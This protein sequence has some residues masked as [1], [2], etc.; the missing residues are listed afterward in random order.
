[1]DRR[2][3]AGYSASWTTEGTSG[4]TP[5]T[6]QDW[7]EI[8]DP[9][10]MLEY[11]RGKA[12]DR[13][14]RLFACAC[15]RQVWHLLTDKRSR[16][17]VE[18]AERYADGEATDA[19]L[20]AVHNDASGARANAREPGWPN[21]GWRNSKWE[22]AGAADWATAIDDTLA[23]A[24]Y[25]AG[26]AREAAG[27]D[28]R[29]GWATAKAKQAAL[30]R[31]IFDNPFRPMTG[32]SSWL[33]WHDRTVSRLAQAAYEERHLPEGTLDNSRL[34]VLA[35]ALEEAGCTNQDI[36]GHLRGPGPHVRGCWPVDLVLGKS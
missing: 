35:D 34:A 9:R 33:T 24:T 28:S 23:V 2:A 11:L 16:L 1:M 15:C 10:L 30:L 14:L 6:E 32:N 36:L 21:P 19:I 22:A 5:M 27:I 8:N 3:V 17:A 25:A 26:S 12:S 18:T 13:K 7:L 29:Y 20:A 31:E 4:E